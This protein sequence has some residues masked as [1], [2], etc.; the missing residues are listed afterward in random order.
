MRI[1]SQREN[2][3]GYVSYIYI[4]IYIYLH[5]VHEHCQTRYPVYRTRLQQ[6]YSENAVFPAV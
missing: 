6:A 1:L 5:S 2:K 4:Y 3:R